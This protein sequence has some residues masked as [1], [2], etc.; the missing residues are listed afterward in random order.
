MAIDSAA[1]ASEYLEDG[2]EDFH[3]PDLNVNEN[4]WGPV[5]VQ[6]EQQPFIRFAPYSR[7]DR[8]GRVADWTGGRGDIGG[9][10]DQYRRGDDRRRRMHLPSGHF[11]GS[12]VDSAFDFGDDREEDATFSLVDRSTPQKRPNFSRLWHTRGGHF[13]GR[14]GHANTYGRGHHHTGGFGQQQVRR[15][16]RRAGG[17][18]KRYNPWSEKITRLKEP[19]VPI[20]STWV[21]IGEFGFPM[22]SKLYYSVGDP[23]DL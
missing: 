22:L 20:E 23:V 17:G 19:S 14:G 7:S 18:Y 2:L 4:G 5:H 21:E 9:P 11:Y 6:E 15:D 3:L 16:D 13:G 8:I 10:P 1:T 12:G